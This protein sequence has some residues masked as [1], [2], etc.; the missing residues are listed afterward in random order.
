VRIK[1]LERYNFIIRKAATRPQKSREREKSSLAHR[2]YECWLKY[3][4]T[5]TCRQ[6]NNCWLQKLLAEFII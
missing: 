3:F 5:L 2:A 4:R 6:I 1:L